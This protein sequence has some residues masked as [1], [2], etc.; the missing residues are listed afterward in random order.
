MIDLEGRLLWTLALKHDALCHVPCPVSTIIT[1]LNC[2]WIYLQI[3]VTVSMA[4]ARPSCHVSETNDGK[5]CFHKIC[6]D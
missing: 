3:I 6:L 1:T 4:T 2:F 5:F